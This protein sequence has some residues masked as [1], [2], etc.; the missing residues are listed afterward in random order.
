MKLEVSGEKLTWAIQKLQKN[1][2]KQLSL[3][4]LE[5]VYLEGKDDSLTLRTTN[6]H[7]GTEVTIPV[8]LI[9]E[10]RTAV[11]YDLFS[12]VLTNL[13]EKNEKIEFSFDGGLF[14][15]KTPYSKF[16]ITSFNADEF[17]TLPK[18]EDSTKFSIPIADFVDGVQSVMYAAAQ[19]DIKPEISSVYVYTEGNELIFVSTDSF[20]LAEK[21]I[22]VEDLGDFPGVIFPIKNVQEFI[23]VFS[24]EDGVFTVLVSENQISF[25][26][27]LLYFVSRV[28]DGNYPNYRQIIPTESLIDVVFLHNELVSSLRL[29]H[30]FSDDF[31]QVFLKTNKKEEKV[32]FSSKNV[33]LGES[34]VKIDAHIHGDDIEV[35]FNYRYLADVLNHPS[36]D[37]I[38]FHFTEAN[39]PFIVRYIDDTSFLYLIM[40]MR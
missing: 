16:N 36:S 20:R 37:S 35:K 18:I 31:H 3:P 27:E 6:L 33:D 1:L 14:V 25:E 40:P 13:K 10:G 9:E 22:V 26:T 30:I 19:S 2:Q 24:K 21:R 7:V 39:K 4:I 5:A 38:S 34:E 32:T 8:K 12:Q 29:V 23:R 15:V 17:P 28:V 11:R